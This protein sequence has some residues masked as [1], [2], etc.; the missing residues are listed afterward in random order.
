VC[1]CRVELL[2]QHDQLARLLQ[3]DK[4]RQQLS[5]IASDEHAQPELGEE[6]SRAFSGQ[7]FGRRPIALFTSERPAGGRHSRSGAEAAAKS[8]NAWAPSLAAAG[9]YPWSCWVRI[10]APGGFCKLSRLAK[11]AGA[12]GMLFAEHAMFCKLAIEYIEKPDNS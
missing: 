9:A 12:A 4:A 7:V 6:E 5:D 3:A 11:H 10:H 8:A 2:A 1:L